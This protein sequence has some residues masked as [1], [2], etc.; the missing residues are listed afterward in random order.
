MGHASVRAVEG[1]A[2]DLESAY[3]VGGE[4]A[5]RLAGISTMNGHTDEAS[6][7]VTLA[8]LHTMLAFASTHHLARLTFWAVNRDR[9]CAAGL[10]PGEDCSGIAQTPFAFTDAIAEYHG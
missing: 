7:T 6:E 5:Y 9:E 1:L 8:D 3:H 10:N 2:R 4:A